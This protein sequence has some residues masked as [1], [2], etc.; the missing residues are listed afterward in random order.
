[1]LKEKIN[2]TFLIEI[3]RFIKNI[4]PFRV[5]YNYGYLCK[6]NKINKLHEYL[7]KKFPLKDYSQTDSNSGKPKRYIFI[8]DK[9]ISSTMRIAVFGDIITRLQSNPTY[10]FFVSREL[11]NKKYEKK[12][13]KFFIF[14][15]Y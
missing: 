1:M 7:I 6:P 12:F 4:N 2:N 10:Q 8:G 13:V 3:F 14:F 15:I 11:I 9:N 5:E